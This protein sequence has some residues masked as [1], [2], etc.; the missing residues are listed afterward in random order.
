MFADFLHSYYVHMP[1][2]YSQ[3]WQYGY[4]HAVLRTESLK[5]NYDEVIFSPIQ[6]RAYIYVLWYGKY[7]PREFWEK[8]MMKKDAFGFYNVDAFDKYT[9]ASP[10][11]FAHLTGK[12][13][14]Y[15]GG[16]AEIP[17][18]SHVLDKVNYLDGSVSYVIADN[19]K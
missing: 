5:D 15:V 1:N 2:K 8:G 14:L 4:K 9:F 17:K 10:S 13:V 11:S 18:D 19:S 6:G 12:R 16:P 3:D 7:T